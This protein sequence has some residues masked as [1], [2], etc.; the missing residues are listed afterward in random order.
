M[1]H[2]CRG[3]ISLHG[4]LIHT[5]DACTFAIGNGGTQTFHIKA[6]SE[7]ERQSWVTALELAK[8][9]AMW[10]YQS[11]V[12]KGGPFS[13]IHIIMQANAI[14]LKKI[15][16]WKGTLKH[17]LEFD[18]QIIFPDPSKVKMVFSRGKIRL[19]H[20]NMLSCCHLHC[21]SIVISRSN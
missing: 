11:L 6:Q 7:V 13:W 4:A 16:I 8:A 1:A 12:V 14:K 10:V 19:S 9:K 5:I 20:S 2:T 18:H 21:L 15:Y 17:V 3:S